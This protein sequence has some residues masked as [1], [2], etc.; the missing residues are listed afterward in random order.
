MY[1]KLDDEELNRKITREQIKQEF[2][3]ES[4]PDYLLS[5]FIEDDDEQALQTAYEFI[6]EVRDEN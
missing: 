5:H 1:L 3:E 4:F 2:P 6:E